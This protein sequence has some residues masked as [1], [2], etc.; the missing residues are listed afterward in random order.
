L[1]D[2][3]APHLPDFPL[4]ASV[5][6]SINASSRKPCAMNSN[7]RMYKYEQGQYFG[8]HYDDSIRD[9]ASG[10]KSEWT[11]SVINMLA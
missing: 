3:L 4:P 10:A 8:A 6:N 7:I 9:A 11:L 2:L 5:K 1:Q